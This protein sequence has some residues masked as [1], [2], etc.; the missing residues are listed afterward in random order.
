MRWHDK[1]GEVLSPYTKAV[2]SFRGLLTDGKP[3]AITRRKAVLKVTLTLPVTK[4]SDLGNLTATLVKNNIIFFT[5]EEN[6]EQNRHLL[7]SYCSNLT[8]VMLEGRGVG[9]VIISLSRKYLLCLKE[10]AKYWSRA[11]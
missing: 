7:L 10:K 2:S 3:G 4:V 5:V 8:E 6:A 11:E 1:V 9:G